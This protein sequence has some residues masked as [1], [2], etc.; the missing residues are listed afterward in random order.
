MSGAIVV[1]EHHH[2]AAQKAASEKGQSIRF[3]VE[4]IL[5]S[6]KDFDEEYQKLLMKEST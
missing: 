3:F 6:D 4:K 5:E 2:D 1:S